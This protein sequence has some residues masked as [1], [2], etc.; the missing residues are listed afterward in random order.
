M[1]SEIEQ[2]LVR[3]G[4]KSRFLVERYKV[5]IAQRDRTEKINQEL[6]SRLEACEKTIETLRLQIEHL[7]MAANIAPTRE[8]LDSTRATISELVREIDRCIAEISD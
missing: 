4:E 2:T 6:K 1:A 7:R 8:S 3:I 5:A